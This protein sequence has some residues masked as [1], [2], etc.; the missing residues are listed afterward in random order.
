VKKWRKVGESG[1]THTLA[2]KQI[3]LHTSPVENRF[4]NVDK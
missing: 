2:H 1:Y 4:T 3:F